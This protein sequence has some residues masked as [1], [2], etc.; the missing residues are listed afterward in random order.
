[1]S[2]YDTDLPEIHYI[3]LPNN[4]GKYRIS[5]LDWKTSVA[6]DISNRHITQ[7]NSAYQYVVNNNQ[8]KIP[9]YTFESGSV[10]GTLKIQKT[11]GTETSID[12]ITIFTPSEKTVYLNDEDKINNEF[13]D[14]PSFSEEKE[15]L[16]ITNLLEN[17][18]Y[19]NF[20][21]EELEEK[22]EEGYKSIQFYGHLGENIKY[23]L[24]Y[25]CD[26]ETLKNYITSQ[27]YICNLTCEI[28]TS[29]SFSQN[30]ICYDV[31]IDIADF[32]QKYA[33]YQNQHDEWE[34]WETLHPGQDKPNEPE[35]P[36]LNKTTYNELLSSTLFFDIK[37]GNIIPKM[38]LDNEGWKNAKEGNP[39]LNP[40]LEQDIIDAILDVSLD[41]QGNPID[42]PV[43][44][45]TVNNIFTSFNT[46]N[47]QNDEY[48]YFELKARYIR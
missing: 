24:S 48:P 2:T 30:I 3:Q 22:L 33:D 40:S 9:R 25:V 12:N 39:V 34:N 4:Q 45:N 10:N 47:N 43:F 46:A 32:Q 37:Q 1:M 5:D 20:T 23:S 8:N 35:A 16:N 7:W 26:I 44:P 42:D 28:L 11:I 21:I 6:K 31:D 19:N 18:N 41:G 36:S 17:S 13:I 15:N 29:F 38:V 14:F 27:S